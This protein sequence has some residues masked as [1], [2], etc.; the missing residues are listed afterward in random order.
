MHDFKLPCEGW[1][2]GCGRP[3]WVGCLV[4]EGMNTIV[5]GMTLNCLLKDENIDMLDPLLGWS[6]GD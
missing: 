4:I 5:L 2:Y 3:C 6:L 1:K